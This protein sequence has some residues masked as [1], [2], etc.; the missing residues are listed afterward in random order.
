MVDASRNKDRGAVYVFT[1]DN[2]EVWSQQAYVKSKSSDNT[3]MFGASVIV[4]GDGNT[5][6]VGS[7]YE[8]SNAI[9]IDGDNTDNSASHAGAVYLY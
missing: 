6:A 9:G 2:S 4:S 7:P 1:R 3:D 8:S 5:L